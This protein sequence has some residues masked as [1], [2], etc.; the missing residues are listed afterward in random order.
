LVDRRDVLDSKDTGLDRASTAKK[1][2][3]DENNTTHVTRMKPFLMPT[4]GLLE[5]SV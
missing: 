4:G 3:S 5:A 1:N 2:L